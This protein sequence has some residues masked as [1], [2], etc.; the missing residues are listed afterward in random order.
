MPNGDLVQSKSYQSTG[1][2]SSHNVVLDA[3]PTQGNLVVIVWCSDAFVGA[4]GV[5][6]GYTQDAKAEDFPGLYCYSKIAGA[7]ESATITINLSAS[8]CCVAYAEERTGM[9]SPA[10]D[11]TAS[12]IGQGTGTNVNTGTTATTTN[13]NDVLYAA[14][15]L[16]LT[17]SQVVNSWDNSFTSKF[18]GASTGSVQN[19]Y[20]GAA[21]KTVSSTGAY[22]ANAT[23]SRNGS[24]HDC[25]LIAAYKISASTDESSLMAGRQCLTMP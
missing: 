3:A 15:G 7:G 25:G 18:G 2:A 19:V 12:A 5:Q 22:T 13:A 6:T 17:A 10:L 8:D 24:S 9:Q 21:T 11:K 16:F 23:L 4:S 20:L 14:A 1:S